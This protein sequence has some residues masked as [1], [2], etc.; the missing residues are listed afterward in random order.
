MNYLPMVFLSQKT[1]ASPVYTRDVRQEEKK[2]EKYLCVFF[3]LCLCVCECLWACVCVCECLLVSVDQPT[4][5]L[6]AE[7]L[8]TKVGQRSNKKKNLNKFFETRLAARR[9]KIMLATRR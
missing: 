3:C 8:T 1:S 4:L 2:L 6:P 5:T 9:R 7:E